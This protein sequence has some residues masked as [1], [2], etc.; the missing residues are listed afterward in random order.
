MPDMPVAALIYDFDKT[1][2]PRDQQE[3]SFLPGLNIDPASFWGECRQLQLKHGMDSVLA[4]ML[5][6]KLRS[7]GTCLLTREGL[8]KLGEAVEFFPGVE[9]IFS[10]LLM[11]QGSLVPANGGL[12][13][14]PFSSRGQRPAGS[15]SR[16]TP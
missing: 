4:Y 13:N 6:M 5:N 16:S 14:T 10:S 7:G 3:Y 9:I 11:Y 1:L 2:S 15:G 8:E 12:E